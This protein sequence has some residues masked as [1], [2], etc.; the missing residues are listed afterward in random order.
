VATQGARKGKK[1][2]SHSW[3]TLS[4][5]PNK[6]ED[7]NIDVVD[8]RMAQGGNYSK[9]FHTR[10]PMGR[11]SNRPHMRNRPLEKEKP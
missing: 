4:K 9:D 7:H 8:L 5:P 1:G 11:A 2:A 3:D 6:E 10:I